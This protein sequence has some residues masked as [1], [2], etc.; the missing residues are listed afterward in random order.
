MLV[1]SLLSYINTTVLTH[2]SLPTDTNILDI[3]NRS[4]S[5]L[6][7]T[8]P[9]QLKE[10]VLIQSTNRVT[11]PL[12]HKHAVTSSEVADKFILD[13][14]YDPFNWKLLKVETLYSEIG[15]ELP[16][17]NYGDN[18]SVFTPTYNT[19]QV[20]Y[21]VSGNN[22]LVICRTD[23]GIL[24]EDSTEIDIPEFLLEAIA[25]H[26][27]YTIFASMGADKPEVGLYLAQYTKLVDSVRMLGLFNPDTY[28]N[29]KLETNRWV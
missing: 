18:T 7:Q 17:N 14:V 28:V 26:V 2:V 10:L 21:P 8:F 29:T 15:L 3:L 19:I 27:A 22:T 24:N 6:C 13:S 9:I 4:I 20:P 23:L 25:A 1:S 5:T 11:Y 12:L 16:I